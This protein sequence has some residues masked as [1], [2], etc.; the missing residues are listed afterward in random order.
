MIQQVPQTKTPR[1]QVHERLRA[2]TLQSTGAVDQLLLCGLLHDS[3][4]D[5]DPASIK[6]KQ[7]REARVYERIKKLGA[8]W[9]VGRP[10]HR[11]EREMIQQVPQTRTP[12]GQVHERLGAATIRSA[13][14]V[15][16]IIAMRVAA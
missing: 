9:V 1:G 13:C 10:L 12:R 8:A 3:G 2:S 14:A 15:G 7:R 16:S 11:V 5:H 6:D 4:G